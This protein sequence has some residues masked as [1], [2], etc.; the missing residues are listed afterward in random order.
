MIS[1]IVPVYNVEN[2]LKQCID[3]II[4]QSYKNIEVL[5]VDDGST[6]NS[7]LICDEY[8]K[9]DNRIRVIHKKNG[10]VSSARNE[11]IKNASGKY[12]QFVDSDDFLDKNMSE[13]MIDTAMKCKADLVICGYKNIYVNDIKFIRC[14]DMAV[15]SLKELSDEFSSLYNK[16]LINSPWNKLYKR[17]RISFFY[18]EKLS[19]GEDLVFNLQYMK[20]VK[21]IAL[22][23]D[24]LYNYRANNSDSL[25]SRYRDDLLDTV[26]NMYMEINRFCDSFFNENIDKTGIYNILT[27]NVIGI[28]QLLVYS[29]NIKGQEKRI[30]IRECIINQ[31]VI[32][33]NKYA[34]ING[35]EHRIVRCFVVKQN[36]W[37]IYLFYKIKKYVYKLL[38]L[39]RMK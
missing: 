7:G 6:D 37:F 5:L 30:K 12:I 31:D 32:K 27:I 1:I 29:T 19:L 13:R 21:K 18:D 25:S 28:L 38:K 11:G 10:G 17:E 16:F 4:N 2:C 33:A 35:F 15:N 9:F 20:N 23:E 14:I 24:C 26:L 34:N 3:S 39:I 36:I 22:I 8:A